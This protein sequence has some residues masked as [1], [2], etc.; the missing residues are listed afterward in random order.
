LT[1]CTGYWTFT[2]E[3]AAYEEDRKNIIEG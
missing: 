1:K 2:G 3:N